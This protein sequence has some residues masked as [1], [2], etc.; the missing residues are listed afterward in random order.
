MVIQLGE[1][2]VAADIESV[3]GMLQWLVKFCFVV[4]EG[5]DVR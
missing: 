2:S 5:D 1:G 3:E 4:I